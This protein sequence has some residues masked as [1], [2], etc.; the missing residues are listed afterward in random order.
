M[1]MEVLQELR[2]MLCRELEEISDKHE[3]SAGDLETVHKLTD[4]IKNIDKICMLECDE[5]YSSDGNWEMEGR[6]S[7]DRGGSYSPR[8]STNSR[9]HYSMGGRTARSRDR[10]GR[11]SSS[12][13]KE[14]LVSQLEELM[15]DAETEKERDAIRRCKEQLD[16]A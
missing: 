3:M 5:D 2:E 15:H 11:Y 7:Y 8:R 4:T 1:S 6:G 12:G 13:A 9:P 10:R 16:K 14:Y